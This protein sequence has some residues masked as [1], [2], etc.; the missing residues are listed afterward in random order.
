MDIEDE[1]IPNRDNELRNEKE[2]QMQEKQ[3][4]DKIKG[5]RKSTKVLLNQQKSNKKLD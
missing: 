1:F 4:D 2:I 5:R 3:S